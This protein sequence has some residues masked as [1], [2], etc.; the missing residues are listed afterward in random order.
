MRCYAQEEPE[1]AHIGTRRTRG[2][3]KGEEK[4]DILYRNESKQRS[5]AVCI[6]NLPQEIRLTGSLPW[7]HSEGLDAMACVLGGP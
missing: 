4:H 2:E 7:D 1:A 3:A 5:T 6:R